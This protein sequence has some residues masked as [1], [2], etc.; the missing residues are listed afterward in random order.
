MCVCVCVRVTGDVG[1]VSFFQG[2]GGGYM[3]TREI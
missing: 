1:P 2:G 3:Y